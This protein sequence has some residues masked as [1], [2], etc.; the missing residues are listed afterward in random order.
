MKLLCTIFKSSREKDMYLYVKHSD[1]LLRVPKALLDKFG[2]PELVTTLALTPDKKLAR[3][4][5]SK[6]I[7]ALDKK[8]F[9]LQLPPPLEE[10]MQGIHRNNAKF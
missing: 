8:G 7:E 2:K 4:E 9:Y 1:Q 5:A 3:V 6:V 10:Y